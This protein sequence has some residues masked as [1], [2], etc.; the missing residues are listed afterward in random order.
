PA[1]ALARP[2]RNA[3]Q[4]GR[5]G[6]AGRGHRRRCPAA[7]MAARRLQLL[8]AER[9]A[10]PVRPGRPRPRR[11]GGADLAGRPDADAEGREGRPGLNDQGAS[12]MVRRVFLR[13]ASLAAAGVGYVP[14]GAAW[15]AASPAR[16]R[17]NPWRPGA[18]KLTEVTLG[19]SAPKLNFMGRWGITAATGGAH[20]GVNVAHV[21][22]VSP[23]VPAGSPTAGPGSV[24]G[25]GSE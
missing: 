15:S 25:S 12:L 3:V 14:F 2:D 24:R 7:G 8:L 21:R 10:R 17:A 23:A 18:M 22:I 13:L 1:L 20:S 11:E 16:P 6:N 9:S 4:P 5:A 19:A